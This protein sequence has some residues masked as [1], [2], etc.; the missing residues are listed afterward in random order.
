MKKKPQTL[1]FRTIGELHA[2]PAEKVDHFC[3]DLALW[4]LFHKIADSHEDVKVSTPRDVFGWI[5][6]GK[7][8]VNVSINLKAE[9]KP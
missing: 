8:N 2:I 3:R 9:G 4:L 6:D 1:E 5:D 7:H